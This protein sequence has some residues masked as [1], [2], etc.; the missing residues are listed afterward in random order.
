MEGAGRERFQPRILTLPGVM[1]WIQGPTQGPPLD[2]PLFHV[3]HSHSIDG[4]KLMGC[5]HCAVR[6]AEPPP[7]L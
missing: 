3:K 7:A 6:T 5:G 2:F 4:L 1:A